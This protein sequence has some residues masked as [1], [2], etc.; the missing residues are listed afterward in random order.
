MM[1]SEV[2]K[3]RLD[4]QLERKILPDVLD[5]GQF[6]SARGQ[7]DRRDV[8]GHVEKARRVPCGS[9][10]Q[11]HGVGAVGDMVGDFVEVEL[12]GL[13]VGVGQGERGAD[14]SGWADGA[15]QVGVVVALVGRLARPR[16]ASGLLSDLAVLL[17]DAGFVLT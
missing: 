2:W 3:T 4:S 11:R 6:G 9:V 7:K 12:H 15:E 10:E 13:G 17:A 1:A 8:V 5:G 16:S 14:A